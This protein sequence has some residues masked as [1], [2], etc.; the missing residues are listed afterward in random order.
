MGIR[1]PARWLL[2][3][4][5][6][7]YAACTPRMIPPPA[8][9]P[10]PTPAGGVRVKR[11]NLSC[12][13]NAQTQSCGRAAPLAQLAARLGAEL[14]AVPPGKRTTPVEAAVSISASW[15]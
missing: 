4:A 3:A 11:L 2:T 8:A 14:E 5:V 9:G 15:C 6:L 12:S 10:A 7:A 1:I 13:A